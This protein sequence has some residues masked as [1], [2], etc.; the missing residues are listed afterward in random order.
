[1]SDKF[2]EASIEWEKG[3]R[4]VVAE[5]DTLLRRVDRL[6]AVAEAAEKLRL[7]IQGMSQWAEV[8]ARDIGWTN[9]NVLVEKADT[10]GDSLSAWRSA[11]E[12]APG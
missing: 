7:E 9:W 6:T 2:K 12:A 1:M 3:F 5:R 8:I 4:E 10:V 11:S